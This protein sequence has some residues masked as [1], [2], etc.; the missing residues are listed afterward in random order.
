MK[1]FSELSSFWIV[2]VISNFGHSEFLS[3]WISITMKFCHSK[4]LL[5]QSFVQPFFLWISVTPNFC[6][7][8][9][10]SFWISVI[11]YAT[12]NFIDSEFWSFW[13]YVHFFWNF[14]H[15]KFLS[16]YPSFLIFF[17]F[18]IFSYNFKIICGP[19]CGQSCQSI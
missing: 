11:I 16:K 5:L 1:Y 3:L 10:P 2:L 13:S 9:V 14:R 4:F 15:S 6:Y 7:S 19:N 8:T 17:Q 12:E 18:S